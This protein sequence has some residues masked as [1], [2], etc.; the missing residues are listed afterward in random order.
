[1]FS[2]LINYK[3]IV[4]FGR[5]FLYVCRDDYD[6]SSNPSYRRFYTKMSLIKFIFIDKTN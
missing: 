1:M 6:E 4:Y 2:L 3:I 5:N